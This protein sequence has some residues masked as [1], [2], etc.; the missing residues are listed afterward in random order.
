MFRILLVDESVSIRTRVR[1]LLALDLPDA[2]IEQ[3][4]PWDAVDRVERAVWSFVVMDIGLS[5]GGGLT[6]LAR[7]RAANPE[8]AI[9]VLSS[10]PVEP[11]ALEVAKRG[12]RAYVH[13]DR[14]SED[15]VSTLCHL[16][17]TQP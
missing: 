8:T 1:Q 2:V 9:I 4:G 15:L 12:A 10:L 11:Y 6:L 7:L 17:R 14:A 5:T 3:V 16:R 13:K